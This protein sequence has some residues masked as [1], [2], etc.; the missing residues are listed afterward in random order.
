MTR[1]TPR[2]SFVSRSEEETVQLGQTLAEKLAPGDVVALRGAIGAGKTTLIRGICAAYGIATASSPTFIIMN[3]HH[4]L[5]NGHPLIVRHFDF[6]RVQEERDLAELGI[7]DFLNDENAISLI[8]WSEHVA[9]H[10]PGSHWTIQIDVDSN[11]HRR[12]DIERS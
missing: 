9:A 5:R 8:E 12:F 11:D 2:E 3:E 4:G 10:L 7:D 6:Y 1:V